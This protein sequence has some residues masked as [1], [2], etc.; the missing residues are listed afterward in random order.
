MDPV[1]PFL[2]PALVRLFRSLLSPELLGRGAALGV[3]T[4]AEGECK[5]IQVLSTSPWTFGLQ[6]M[7]ARSWAVG[8]RLAVTVMV[9]AGSLMK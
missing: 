2:V 6:A 3:N 8:V 4:Q 5:Q 1:F 9:C 7:R